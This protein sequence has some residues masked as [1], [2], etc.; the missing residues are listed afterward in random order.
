MRLLRVRHNLVTEQELGNWGFQGGL[1]VKNLTASAG[2]ARDSDS[3][4]VLGRFPGEGNGNSLQYSCP[5]SPV[6][7]E[8]GG[9]QS[10]GSQR[11]SHN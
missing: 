1:V 11:V 4:P 9:L 8:P 7:E 2:D 6:R 10:M 5:E 3:I